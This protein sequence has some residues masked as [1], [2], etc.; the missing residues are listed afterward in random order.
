MNIEDN[1][2]NIL[3]KDRKSKKGGGMMMIKSMIKVINVEY[4]KGKVE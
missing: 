4:E 3:R 1:N 2:R